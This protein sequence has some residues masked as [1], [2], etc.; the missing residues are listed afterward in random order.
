MRSRDAARFDVVPASGTPERPADLGA[1]G[2]ALWNQIIGEH[3]ARKTLGQIDTAALS[4]LCRTWELCQAAYEAA[5]KSATDKDARCSYL[6]YLAACDK[7]GAKFG[8]TASDRANMKIG[9]GDK[10]TGVPTRI[11]A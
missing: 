2:A 8:W 3:A 7:L 10:R 5:K 9:S 4:A 1:I 6:G 11:R